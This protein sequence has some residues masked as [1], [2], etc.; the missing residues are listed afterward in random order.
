M[1]LG[2]LP[3]VRGGLGELARTGQHPRL[4]DGY[5]RPYARAFSEVRY[6]SYLAE[7]LS[8]YTGDPELLTRVRV[9]PGRFHPWAWSVLMALA[10]RRD[11]RECAVIRAFQMTG[12]IPAL[13]A[14]QCWG[15]PFVA[16]YG[17]W[18]GRLA[19]S[20]TTRVLR[21]A[22]V[23]AGL[24][25]AAGVIVTTPELAAEVS[26]RLAASRVHLIPNGVDVERFLPVARPARPVKRLLYVGRLSPE[27]NLPT[28]I[29]AAGQLRRRVDVRLTIVGQGPERDVLEAE[30]ARRRVPVD[31]R[32]VVEHHRLPAI[33]GEADAFVLPSFIE[34]H[35]KALLEAMSCGL[36]CVVSAVR[37]NRTLVTDGLTGLLFDPREPAQLAEQL[38][39]VL[40][41]PDLAEGLG[42]RARSVVIEQYDLRALVG[43]E[44]ALLRRVVDQRR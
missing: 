12:V 18:Y 39:R 1:V 33:F 41:D 24:A 44:I 4:I 26:R 22:V 38:E 2:L 29:E 11:L 6:F 27:K 3:S 37:G 31:L 42:A 5:F 30:A 35:P 43:R 13:V 25:A 20:R 7:S 14:H 23:R 34:G 28:L 36:P 21:G 9:F 10:H 32:P 17:F 15:V 16:T 8:Q 19:G 40:T